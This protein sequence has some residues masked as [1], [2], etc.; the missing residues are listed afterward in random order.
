MQTSP[1]PSAAIEF[2]YNITVGRY[3]DLAGT[4]K[5]WQ[6][7][8]ADPFLSR[9]FAATLTLTAPGLMIFAGTFYGTEPEFNQLNLDFVL[10]FGQEDFG[11]TVVSRIATGLIHSLT[12]FL[13]DVGGTIPAHFY[14]NSLKC[15]TLS[16]HASSDY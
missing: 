2:Q 8:I 1:P 3:A 11:I 5:K 6:Q 13:Y 9:Y 14:S 16:R 4:F 12:D 15:K 7:L 10:P